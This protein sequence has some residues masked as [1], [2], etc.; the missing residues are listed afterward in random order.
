MQVS[1]QRAVLADIAVS[2]G[3]ILPASLV[4]KCVLDVPEFYLRWAGRRLSTLRFRDFS[5][6]LL[7]NAYVCWISR[8]FA[9]Q[10]ISS[11][12]M[13]NVGTIHR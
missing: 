5:Q 8:Q 6:T 4:H 3:P 1:A 10:D 12:P 9:P 2:T 13:L 11:R 7:A